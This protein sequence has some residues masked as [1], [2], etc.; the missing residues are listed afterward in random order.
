MGSILL[1]EDE[2]VI[3]ES[4][5]YALRSEGLVAT[6]VR[7]GALASAALARGGIDLVVLDVGLPDVSGFELCRTWRRSSAVPILFLTA[8]SAEIDR[9]VGLE[10][11]ADDYVV[12]PFSPREVT[13]RIRAILRRCAAPVS[14][15]SGRT[16]FRVDD[17]RLAITYRGQALALSRVQFRLLRALVQR[18]GRIF[19]RS[20]LIDEAS[21]GDPS[22]DRTVDSHI[23]DLRAKLRAVDPA[24]DAILTRRGEGY[25]LREDW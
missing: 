21:G 1:V 22:L 13:A 5:L 17:D 24:V 4:L 3:A 23:K 2:A 20:Q 7:D 8:R 16:P 11:G 18:P 10:L 19:S 25:A 14:A 6:W 9:V 15:E 12:K